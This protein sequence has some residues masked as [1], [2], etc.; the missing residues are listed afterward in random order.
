MKRERRRSIGSPGFIHEVAGQHIC[1]SRMSTGRL[2]CGKSRRELSVKL[3]LIL[4]SAQRNSERPGDAALV[5][6]RVAAVSGFLRVDVSFSLILARE[7]GER[8]CTTTERLYAGV[9]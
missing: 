1:R 5:I 9:V 8:F 7:S 2:R 6:V 4:Q 3:R